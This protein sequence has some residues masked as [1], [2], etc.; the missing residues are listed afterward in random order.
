MM[1]MTLMSGTAAPSAGWNMR[2]SMAPS[3]GFTGSSSYTTLTVLLE[4]NG[5]LFSVVTKV[6]QISTVGGEWTLNVRHPIIVVIQASYN[7]SGHFCCITKDKW[8]QN[9]CSR[10]MNFQWLGNSG[11]LLSILQWAKHTAS[12]THMSAVHDFWCCTLHLDV[13]VK[14]KVLIKNT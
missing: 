2:S 8:S 12:T 7:C 10:E 9:C 11:C 6:S 3:H 4:G 5:L 14:P 1:K 13:I